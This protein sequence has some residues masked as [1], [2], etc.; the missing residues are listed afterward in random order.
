MKDEEHF[1]GE[2]VEYLNEEEKQEAIKYLNSWVKFFCR[3]LP[4]LKLMKP[5]QIID[6]PKIESFSGLTF[7][8]STIG[9]KICMIGEKPENLLSLME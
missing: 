9:V 7:P 3:K 6:R 5:A 2:W 1:F 8:K 4:T